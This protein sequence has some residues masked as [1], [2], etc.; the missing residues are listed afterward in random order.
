MIEST[1]GWLSRIDAEVMHL[2]STMQKG[3]SK[4]SGVL[5][6]GTYAGRSALAL[7]ASIGGG[8]ILY[9]CDPY[10]ESPHTPMLDQ[11]DGTRLGPQ[12]PV[13]R[14]ATCFPTLSVEFLQC[15]SSELSDR[16]LR[17]LKVRLV[18]VDG[19]HSYD[20]CRSDILWALSHIDSI[21][22]LIVVDDYRSAHTPGV[23]AAFWELFLAELFEDCILTD[24]KAY[25]LIGKQWTGWSRALLRVLD[26]HVRMYTER[27]GSR[28]LTRVLASG[29]PFGRPD[30][31]A[32]S[33][34][35][36]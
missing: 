19:S 28:T 7:G 11:V 32:P 34:S 33:G 6:I 16:G 24:H 29:K 2:L 9:L 8:E 26:G 36:R 31:M 1:P 12:V 18:H 3:R 27:V 5:E 35:V 21:M 15:K 14:L 22:G 13:G 30:C 4:G 20:D 17:E 25:A 10:L 23:A